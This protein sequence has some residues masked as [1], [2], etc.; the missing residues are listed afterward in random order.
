MTS[1]VLSWSGLTASVAVVAAVVLDTAPCYSQRIA[2]VGSMFT[3]RTAGIAA[4]TNA[5][6]LTTPPT[7]ADVSLSRAWTSNRSEAMKVAAANAPVRSTS[8]PL[9]AH[10]IASHMTSPATSRRV[11]P[12]AIRTPISLVR[13]A[14]VCASAPLTPGPR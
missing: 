14:I 10:F 13:D 2:I 4:A 5:T 1:R 9:H 12:A 6:S 7:V 3:A 11:A 8:M